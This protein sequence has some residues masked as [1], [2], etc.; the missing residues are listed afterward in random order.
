MP[1]LPS[2]SGSP[3]SSSATGELRRSD[4]VLPGGGMAREI[5]AIADDQ[6]LEHQMLHELD[7]DQVDEGTYRKKLGWQF[8]LPL[9]WCLIVLFFAVFQWAFEP[10]G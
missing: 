10:A 3:Y 5:G 8:W 4:E 7:A 9:S 6:V 2:S 1:E